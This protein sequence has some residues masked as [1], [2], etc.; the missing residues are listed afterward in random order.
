MTCPASGRSVRAFWSALYESTDSIDSTS[1]VNTGVSTKSMPD[2]TPMAHTWQG[3]LVRG[4]SQRCKISGRLALALGVPPRRINE[5][6]LGER[7]V[8]AGTALQLGR[9]FRI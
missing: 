1:S 4:A 9:Y 7:G 8:A 3:R 5:I 6:V 2:Y